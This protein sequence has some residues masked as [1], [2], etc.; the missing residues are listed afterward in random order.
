MINSF[1]RNDEINGGPEIS[2]EWFNI[3]LKMMHLKHISVDDS[4]L[5]LKYSNL[6]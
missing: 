1:R 4:D 2:L 5:Q 6:Y 3:G